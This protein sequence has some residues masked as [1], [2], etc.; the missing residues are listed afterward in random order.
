MLSA[1]IFDVDGTLADTERYGHRVAFNRAFERLDQPD[2]WDESFYGQLLRIGGGKERLKH[3]L[4]RY[5]KMSAE[6]SESLA[7]QLHKAKNA[8]FKELIEEGAIPVRPGVIRLLDEL[9]RGSITVAVATTGSREWVTLLLPS[10]LGETRA[11]RFTAIVTGDEVS[12]HK[13]DPEVYRLALDRLGCPPELAL[14][15]EDSYNGVEAA[16]RAGLGCLAVRN[17]YSEN[18]DLTTSDLVVDGFG[19]SGTPPRVLHNPLGLQVDAQVDLETL[20]QLQSLRGMNAGSA[21]AGVRG[22]A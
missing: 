14:A 8:A 10:L 22:G 6:E 19:D 18:Q 4:E 7:A 11:A 3:Y 20:R 13:P 17:G 2:R 1:V 15:I 21:S 12:L 5:R 9:E 16:K